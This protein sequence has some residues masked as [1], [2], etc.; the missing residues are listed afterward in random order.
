ML[1][2]VSPLDMGLRAERVLARNGWEIPLAYAG[3]RPRSTLFVTDLSHVPKWI[4]QGSGL[5]AVRPAGLNMPAKPGMITLER[6]LLLVRCIPSECR[7]MGL[8]IE[9]PVF[10]ETGFTDVADAYAA[11]AL[12]GTRCFDVLAKLSS[13][14]LEGQYSPRAALAPVEDVTCLL[15]RIEGTGGVPGII[16]AGA[17]GYGHF[18][19]D[20]LLDA[21]REYSI[22]AAGW[23]RF[24]Q[25][26]AG[27]SA[28][29]EPELSSDLPAAKRR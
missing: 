11:I 22:Q 7:I 13:I 18:L 20:A 28:A 21:G 6:S 23:E 26:I 29:L 4:L 27:A 5:D 15:V 17:R 10:E 12:V 19:L 3:E 1:K 2:R 8:G 14:D 9:T 25:W 24:S 16:L